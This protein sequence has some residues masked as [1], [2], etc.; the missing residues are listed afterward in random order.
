MKVW[1]ALLFSLLAHMVLITQVQTWR[2]QQEQTERFR[3]RLS[4]VP[5]FEPKRLVSTQPSTLAPRQMEYRRQ[6]A[7]MQERPELAA[8]LPQLPLLTPPELA[9]AL[10]PFAVAA[11]ADTFSVETSE[12][13]AD[14][15]MSSSRASWDS[16]RGESLDLLRVE[17]LAAAG[18]R[19]AVVL[20]DPQNRRDVT[21][22]V[23]LRRVRARGAGG[24]RLGLDVL[25][26]HMRDH[27]QLLVQVHEQTVDFFLSENLL[28]DPIHFLIQGGGLPVIGGWPPLQI[29]PGEKEI[30]RR[31]ILG[32]GLLFVEGSNAFL[33]EGI[34]LMQE[35]IGAD[36]GMRPMSP[37]HPLYHAYYD[38]DSGFPSEVKGVYTMIDSQP[39]RWAYP[40][41]GDDEAVAGAA[42]I[43]PALEAATDTQTRATPLGLWEVQHEGRTV[44]I[45][46]DIGLHAAWVA[47]MS[48]DEDRVL[49]QQSGP[50]LAAGINLIVYA[51]TRDGGNAVRRALPAWMSK[52]PMVRP[53]AGID[54]TSS[55]A[56]VD[57]GF[58]ESL[59]DD[60]AGAV[61]VVC[62]PIGANFGPGS[63]IIR[64]DGHQVEL[65]RDDL[66]G[67]MLNNLPPG[68]H[69][70]E[71]TWQGNTESTLVQVEGGQVTT[72]TLSVQRLAMLK[73]ILLE[74][75][76]DIVGQHDWLHTFDDLLIEEIFLEGE[77][78]F[79]E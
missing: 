56:D 4:Q 7:R 47:A 48:L 76:P 26:R 44:A 75:Q 27:T 34:R 25:A 50:K 38:F 74:T 11:K 23:T 21:G 3:A 31:Y 67:V 68:E 2:T 16:L 28:A 19:P 54:D 43:N 15:A 33:Q 20:I 29:G 77:A 24:G 12:T 46:S 69:W 65:F 5:R 70:V 52:R 37:S 64:I 36:G 79:E 61:A 6:E 72:V 8:N 55:T 73:R 39:L 49:D 14:R 13:Q 71:A 9:L 10:R 32:G 57:A 35:L 58:D 1:P 60:L 78:I 62:A 17:D 40:V 45:F 59:Y 18:N 30:L 66:N 42:N 63:V 41:R 51:I 22:F 53:D